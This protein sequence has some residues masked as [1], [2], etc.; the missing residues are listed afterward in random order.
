VPGTHIFH[1]FVERLVR[2]GV[3]AGCA[4]GHFCVDS[5][6]TRAQMSIFLL[7]AKNGPGYVPP[8]ATGTMFADVP[9]DG[10]AAA[11]IERLSA[12]GVTVGCG[13]GNFCPG[14]PVT[15]EQ[16]AVFLLRTLEGPSYIPPL[17]TTAPF[18][19]VP[20][21]SG[22]ARWIQE[23]ALRG[24]TAGCGGGN[25]CPGAVAARGQMAV[26]LAE[27]FDIP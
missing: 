2:H 13:G 14:D 20:C 7:R 4:S 6:V 17:C 23:L 10:F 21:S 18:G 24:I 8:A 11:W 15:R 26:F 5:P 9:V 19:D 3:S 16:M 25:F 22:F 27:T 1:D 12:L